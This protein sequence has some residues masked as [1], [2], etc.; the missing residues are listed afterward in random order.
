MTSSG[1]LGM[2][3]LLGGIHVLETFLENSSTFLNIGVGAR[4]KGRTSEIIR[5]DI[6]IV[7]WVSL[8]VI[9]FWELTSTPKISGPFEKLLELLSDDIFDAEEKTEII[10]EL[11]SFDEVILLE[12][13]WMVDLMAAG[14][15]F[16]RL[17]MDALIFSEN[18]EEH[19]SKSVCN[20]EVLGI[21]LC[22]LCL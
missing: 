16:C 8:E 18:R 20:A 4:L 15:L 11:V 21:L 3:F 7:R 10:D 22:E 1:S 17:V 9:N 6:A 2:R 13:Q 5:S 19:P 14:D 12:L